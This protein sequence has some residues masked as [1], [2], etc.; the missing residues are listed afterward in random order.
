VEGCTGDS[1]LRLLPFGG[2][3]PSRPAPSVQGRRRVPL[4]TGTATL[5]F[6]PHIHRRPH[7]AVS[8]KLRVGVSVAARPMLSTK[9]WRSSDRERVAEADTLICGEDRLYDPSHLIG[10]LLWA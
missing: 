5:R 3:G 8:M 1:Q 6:D 10:R 2:T 9:E 4:F 7:A